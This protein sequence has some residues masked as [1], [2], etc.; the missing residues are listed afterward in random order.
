[1][2]LISEYLYLEVAAGN[3]FLQGKEN[4]EEVAELVMALICGH[5][6]DWVRLRTTGH[7]EWHTEWTVLERNS[8]DLPTQIGCREFDGEMEVITTEVI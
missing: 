4:E 1:V 8:D 2:S 7:E 6:N 3:V 5:G